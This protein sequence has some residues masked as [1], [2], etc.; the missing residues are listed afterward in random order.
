MQLNVRMSNQDFA[1]TIDEDET[2]LD[3]FESLV[4][5]RRTSLLIDQNQ[6]VADVLVA[7]LCDL[8][9]WA[10]NH[11]RTWPW[12]VSIVRGDGR[13]RL[14]LACAKDLIELGMTDE[15]RLAK[16]RGK[17]LR[18]PI[19]LAV[20]QQPESDAHRHG[21]DRDAVAAGIQ[22]FLLGAHAAGLASYWGS[23]PDPS[24]VH[25]LEVCG[26]EPGSRLSG[27]I[28]LGWPN[29]EVAVPERPLLTIGLID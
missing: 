11:K 5:T 15:S 18:A 26:F 23:A 9:I 4:F 21:E 2:P 6:M 20:G 27:L 25:T 22:N 24:G 12:L 1:A 28:Y 7:R 17:Y 19:I 10:P 8:L 14:G 13:A 3:V 29:G 16:T